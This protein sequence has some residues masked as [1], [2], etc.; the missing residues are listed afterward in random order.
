MREHRATPRASRI[1]RLMAGPRRRGAAR[2]RHGGNRIKRLV[3]AG[4]VFWN[5]DRAVLL[6]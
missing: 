5:V 3:I 6:V 4:K 1:E 2:A